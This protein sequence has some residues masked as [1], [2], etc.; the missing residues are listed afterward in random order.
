MSTAWAPS[1]MPRYSSGLCLLLA[2]GA[3]RRFF[4]LAAAPIFVAVMLPV[5]GV[6]NTND[7]R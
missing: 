7:W 6:E 3:A 2:Q 1:G 4:L 5:N